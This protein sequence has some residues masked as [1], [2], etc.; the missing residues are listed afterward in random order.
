MNYRRNQTTKEREEL[1]F[2]RIC[3]HTNWE[4]KEHYIGGTER[5]LVCLAKEL[6]A[7]GHSPFILCSG[8][9]EKYSVEGVEVIGYMPPRYLKAYS[10]YPAVTPEFLLNEVVGSESGPEALRQLSSFTQEQLSTVEA[11]IYHLNSFASALFVSDSMP[12]VVS[13]HENKSEYDSYWGEGFF[14]AMCEMVRE[15][16]TNLHKHG[17]LVTPSKHYA[18]EYSTLLGSAVAGINLGICLSD[19]PSHKSSHEISIARSS[20]EEIKVLLPSRFDT[21]QK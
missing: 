18:E 12:V 2:M 14:D 3:L 7:L 17:A 8:F 10:K 16:K 1:T 4:I 9:S 11:D 15:K 19:F 21:Y 20:Q 5:L 6:S 13:N